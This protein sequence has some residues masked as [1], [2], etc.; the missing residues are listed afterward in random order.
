M[1]YLRI[2]ADDKERWNRVWDLYEKS[3]PVAERRKI[4]DHLRACADE[5]FFPLSIWEG[6]QL[7]GLMFF[8]EWD[9]YR[10]LEHLAVN[11]EIRGHGYGSQ[12]L[13]Y[14][15]DSEH[16]IILEIDPLDDE[17]SVRRLQFYERSGYTLTPFRFVHLPYRI[18]GQ[19]Q[20]LLIL[21]YPKMISKDQHK[22]F[23]KFVNEVVI[24]Y[25]EGYT[26]ES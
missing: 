21:S 24:Q 18:D 14:L 11:P 8:W 15:C 9:T 3:F 23:L 1:E 5:R 6:Q 17:L 12:L 20:E 19:E 16:T 7:I 10:Y 22:D 25:C 2:E 26:P 13:R 4:N